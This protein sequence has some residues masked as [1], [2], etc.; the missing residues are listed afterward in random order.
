[1]FQPQAFQPI[2]PLQASLDKTQFLDP[3]PAMSSLS[4][5]EGTQPGGFKNMLADM[6][7]GVNQTVS[8]PDALM[9]QAMTTGGVDVHDVM[10]ANA[11]AELAVNI[12]AQVVTKV[13]Q[14]YDRVLQIQV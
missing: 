5:T 12:T 3:M 11:K 13:I 2:A 8:A 4:Q 6:V 10:I 9:Q 14:A 7:K 1:M